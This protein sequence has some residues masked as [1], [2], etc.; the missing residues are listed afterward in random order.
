M[1]TEKIARSHH[2]DPVSSTAAADRMNGSRRAQANLERVV[3]AVWANPGKTSGELVACVPGLDVHE[4]RRRL[5]DAVQRQRI[6]RGLYRKCTCPHCDSVQSTYY[7][8]E[9]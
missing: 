8:L 4:I 3:V 1:T 7:P 5:T 2:G 6:V 9:H